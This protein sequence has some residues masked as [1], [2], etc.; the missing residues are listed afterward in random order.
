MTANCRKILWGVFERRQLKICLDFDSFGSV[1][2]QEFCSEGIA[3]PC[4]Y[5]LQPAWRSWLPSECHVPETSKPRWGRSVEGQR[6]ETLPFHS[7]DQNVQWGSDNIASIIVFHLS[8]L[9]KP[10]SSY[11]V[12]LYFWWGCRGNLKSI[13]LWSEWAK[14]NSPLIIREQ[15]GETLKLNSLCMELIVKKTSN[16]VKL[17]GKWCQMHF[18]TASVCL[19]SYLIIWFNWLCV[20]ISDTLRSYLTQLRQ[21]LGMRLVEKVYSDSDKPSKVRLKW[22]GL[23]LSLLTSK[24][25]FSQLPTYT[26][27]YNNHLS[28]E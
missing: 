23:S 5:E 19:V 1:S 3:D 28:S 21:E 16:V 10:S 27:V 14:L 4:Y 15:F 24:G 22:H 17:Y 13:T 25:S 11:C 6:D 20:D 18:P 8:K 12:M 7:R 26:V 9:W 2:N